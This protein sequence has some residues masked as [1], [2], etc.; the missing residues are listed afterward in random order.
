[1]KSVQSMRKVRGLSLVELLVSVAIGLVV[2]GAVVVAFVGSGKAGRYQ[3]ALIQMNQDA[4]IGLSLL[5]REV[6]LAGYSAPRTLSGTSTLAVAYDP[7]PSNMPA[8]FGCD[9][10]SQG[11]SV[12]TD[13]TAG[14]LACNTSSTATPTYSGFS[15]A[16]EAEPQNTIPLGTSPTWVPTDCLGNTATW[17]PA[18]TTL[19]ML[20]HYTVQ[21]RYYISKETSTNNSGR[22]E[23]FCASDTTTAG[24]NNQ[25]PLLENVEDMQVWYGVA[26]ATRQIVK[27]EKAGLNAST[28][29]TINA[30][31]VLPATPQDWA[32]VTSVRICLLLRSAEPVQDAR[33]DTLPYLDC[34]N[35]TVTATDHYLRRA[36]YTTSTLR[37]RMQF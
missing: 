32:T 37:S 15:V 4:Q 2:I 23:L 10:S 20:G 36:Y 26:N 14:L 16:Y 11:T 30:T 21:N 28:P 19:S 33:E 24:A 1:M 18:S 34:N 25:K 8:I 29:G 7:L 12:F 6:Q 9:A 5:A 3:S 17:V 27:W 22:P 13:P 35:N 31:A